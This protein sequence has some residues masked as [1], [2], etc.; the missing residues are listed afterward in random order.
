MKYV[1]TVE[2]RDEMRCTRSIHASE[3]RVKARIWG[4]V[5]LWSGK[6]LPEKRFNGLRGLG[7]SPSRLSSIVQLPASVFRT[8]CRDQSHRQRNTEVTGSASE[9]GRGTSAWSILFVSWRRD[10]AEGETRKR[11]GNRLRG[12]HECRDNAGR[13]TPDEGV[14]D[15]GMWGSGDE[16]GSGR[17]DTECNVLEYTDGW[18]VPSLTHRASSVE[19]R[20]STC[21][22]GEASRYA[23]TAA[24]L[25]ATGMNQNEKQEKERKKK[26]KRSR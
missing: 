14:L 24:F 13:S 15:D 8:S 3:G 9:N 25:L 5:V 18:R 11:W 26:G 21:G 2:R 10:G 16:H 19:R 4:A 17:T 23:R 6:T 1:S 12:L 7:P 22:E 20:S